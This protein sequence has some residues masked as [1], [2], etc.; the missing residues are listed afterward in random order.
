MFEAI[1]LLLLLGVIV[2]FILARGGNQRSHRSTFI[3][4]ATELKPAKKPGRKHLF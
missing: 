4:L 3:D 1:L 2:W